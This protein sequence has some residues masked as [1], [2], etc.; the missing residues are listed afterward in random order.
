MNNN[1]MICV[2][3]LQKEFWIIKQPKFSIRP[4]FQQIRPKQLLLK[5][6]SWLIYRNKSMM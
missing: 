6:K 2:K 3:K 5:S 4:S 1:L